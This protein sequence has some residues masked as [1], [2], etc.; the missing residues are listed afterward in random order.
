MRS[1]QTRGS[2]WLWLWLSADQALGA[3]CVQGFLLQQSLVEQCWGWSFAS[4]QQASA[5]CQSIPT[6]V[7]LLPKL[8]LV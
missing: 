3:L 1:E 2:T 8:R 4:A 6:F 7:V 5:R